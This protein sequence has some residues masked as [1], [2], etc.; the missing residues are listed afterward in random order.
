MI[1]IKPTWS[2]ALNSIALGLSTW[3]QS[4]T[5]ARLFVY[6][7]CH[8][9]VKTNIFRF[10]THRCL[11][12]QDY[13]KNTN[14]HTH[15]RK[16]I[17]EFPQKDLTNTYKCT[18]IRYTCIVAQIPH[19]KYTLIIL[20]RRFAT[21]WT[22]RRPKGWRLLFGLVQLSARRIKSK[23]TTQTERDSVTDDNLRSCSFLICAVELG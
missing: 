7:S 11:L 4:R 15:V 6:L 18:N 22:S 17:V 19:Q 8:C 5:S 20:S 12:W 13:H 3:F 14:S 1:V 16:C 9:A 23:A 2:M 10:N 21:W